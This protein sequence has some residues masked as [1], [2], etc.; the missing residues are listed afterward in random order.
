[1]EAS[2]QGSTYVLQGAGKSETCRARKKWLETRT[3]HH[4]MQ[5]FWNAKSCVVTDQLRAKYSTQCSRCVL[6][7][8]G[9]HG[10]IHKGQGV[11]N[12]SRSL[13]DTSST[14]LFQMFL[15]LLGS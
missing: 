14:V 4:T 5:F 6:E 9:A 13:R 7:A 11:F 2:L 15:F 1:M 3:F 10:V 8:Q 12:T